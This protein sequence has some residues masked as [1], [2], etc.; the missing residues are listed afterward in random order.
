MAIKTALLILFSA[1]N[2]YG[3]TI[4]A[5]EDGNIIAAV[6]VGKKVWAITA[7]IIYTCSSLCKE[8]N[9]ER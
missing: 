8:K 4:E 6:E 5:D 3:A 2:T 9:L 1:A 7:Y